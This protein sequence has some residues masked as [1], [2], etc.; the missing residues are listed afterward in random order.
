MKSGEYAGPRNTR[1]TS[2]RTEKLHYNKGK[3]RELKIPRLQ[4]TEAKE[5]HSPG[6]L[7]DPREHAKPGILKGR[8]GG[9][10]T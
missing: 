7:K 3:R 8:K 10:G 6:S 5:P 2:S 4:L 1:D 9:T